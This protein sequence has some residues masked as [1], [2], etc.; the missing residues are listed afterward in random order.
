[1]EEVV[2]SAKR[3]TDIVSEIATA[4]REQL[5][6][7]EQVGSAMAQMEH[8]VQQNAAVV[9]QTAAAAENMAALADDLNQAVARFTLDAESRRTVA[10]QPADLRERAVQPPELPRAGDLSPRLSHN[11]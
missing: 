7:I 10:Q 9:E 6:G 8:V 4:S 5:A 2:T 1:M 3:V 11:A